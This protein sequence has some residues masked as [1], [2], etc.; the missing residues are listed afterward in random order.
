MIF[1]LSHI[2]IFMF[3]IVEYIFI[4]VSGSLLTGLGY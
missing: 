4:F 2:L 3:P 1:E